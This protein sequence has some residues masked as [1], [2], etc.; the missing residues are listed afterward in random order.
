MTNDPRDR[1][2][3]GRPS[4]GPRTDV[5]SSWVALAYSVLNGHGAETRES[6]RALA[7]LVLEESERHE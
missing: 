5:P 6:A 4:T 7:T 1:R 3:A 2:Q